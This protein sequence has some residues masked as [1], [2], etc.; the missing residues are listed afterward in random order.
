M[1]RE[2]VKGT[3]RSGG[4]TVVQESLVAT[5][6][7][8]HAP[9]TALVE[10]QKP[11]RQP[12]STVLAQNAWTV[13]PREDYERLSAPYPAAWRTRM[14]AR[15]AVA[16]VNFRRADRVVCLSQSMGDLVRS[17]TRASVIVAPALAPMD[18]WA[19]AASDDDR[20][21]SHE[22]PQVLVPGTITW[23]KRPQLALQ[24]ARDV[25]DRAGQLPRV[26]FAGRDDGTGAWEA[27]QR[28]AHRL[29]LVVERSPLT[30]PQMIKALRT[31]SVTILPSELESLS[32]SLSE[33]LIFSPRVIA[34]SLAVHREVSVA[35]GRTPEWLEAWLP[36]DA[37]ATSSA[38]V[39]AEE[40]RAGWRRVGEA[41][42]L[43]ER[44]EEGPVS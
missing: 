5:G 10:A 11:G 1:M 32:L 27:T 25:G 19:S 26:L 22:H 6:F 38:T 14:A 4:G 24:I 20:T 31:Y 44:A 18:I 13:L 40:A 2:D 39:T 29:G 28:E 7:D 42:Q 43:P 33:S 35:L 12:F 9:R 41:L 36:R 21:E 30:R 8:I 15:R 37:P 17:A 16:A 34:S 23:Y 3:R